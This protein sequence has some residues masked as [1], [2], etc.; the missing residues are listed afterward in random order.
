LNS[1]AVFDDIHVCQLVMVGHRF[2][3]NLFWHIEVFRSQNSHPVETQRVAFQKKLKMLPTWN[4]E[5]GNDF[6]NQ[7]TTLKT[8]KTLWKRANEFENSGTRLRTGERF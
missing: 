2:E 5:P 4:S 3:M 6:E 8:G 1:D 7:E